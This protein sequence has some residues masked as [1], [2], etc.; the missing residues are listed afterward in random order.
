MLFGD[1]VDKEIR[2]HAPATVANVVCGFDCLGF[3]I[4]APYDEITVSKKETPGINI[5]DVGGSGL[6]TASDKNVAGVA[7]GAMIADAGLTHGFNVAIKKGIKPGSGI[8]SSAASSAGAVVAANRL[9]DDRFS[10]TDLVRFAMAGER[11]ASGTAHADNV[12]PCIFGG[13]TLVRSIDPLD[14]AELDHPELFAVVIHPQIEIKTSDARGLL[15]GNIPMPAAVAYWSN[16]GAFVSA[17]AKGD[18]GMLGRAMHDDIIEP[19]RSPLIPH[20]SEVKDAAMNSGAIGGG[21]SGS[22]PS[23]FYLA[24][25]RSAA[26]DIA[27]AIE[28]VYAATGIIFNI[29]ISAIAGSGVKII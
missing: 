28:A 27:A 23:M 12:A 26:A 25:D 19:A 1:I 14:V 24:A 7:L 2:V 15:P 18:V 4:D 17:L 20:Y 10:K 6:P 13:F 5:T 3:A 16:L 29:H 21:I 11:L 9:L 8:G 22:G